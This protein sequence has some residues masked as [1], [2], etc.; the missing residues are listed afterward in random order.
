M[1]RYDFKSS[2][3]FSSVLAYPG[4]V[5]V[6]ELGSDGTMLPWFLLVMILHFTFAIYLSLVLAGLSVSDCGLS[7]L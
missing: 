1:M 4:F 2:S 7:V 6:E 5:I 3:C